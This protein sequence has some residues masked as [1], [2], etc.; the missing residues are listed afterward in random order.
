MSDMED[1]KILVLDDDELFHQL[2]SLLLDSIGYKNVE[3]T[4]TINEALEQI[5][6][7]KPDILILDINLNNNESGIDFAKMINKDHKIP[8]IFITS[9]YHKDIY[10]KAKLT[11]PCQFLDKQLS[12]LKLQQAIE[13]TVLQSEKKEEQVSDQAYK[14]IVDRLNLKSGWFIRKG[15]Y[16]KKVD[17]QD[18]QWIESEGKYCMVYTTDNSYAASMPLKEVADRL[19][20]YNFLRIHRSFVINREKIQVLD[21]ENNFV[22][23]GEHEIPI[24]RNYRKEL[25]SQLENI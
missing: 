4:Q 9:N 10:S 15:K 12:E 22:K 2:L 23:V 7:F 17:I 20:P 11:G 18:I 25:I 19:I 6:L 5:K 14:K 3:F 1:L 8:I 13:L 24:G 16:L 21:L